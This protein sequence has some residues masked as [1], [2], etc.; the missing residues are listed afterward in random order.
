EGSQDLCIAYTHDITERK[1]AEGDRAH[2]EALLMAAIAQTPA[3]VIIADAPDVRIRIA[4]SAAL[5]IRGEARYALTG[6]PINLHPMHWQTFHPD[7]TPFAPEDLPLSR[8]ILYGE[9]SHDVDVII[10]RETGEDRWVLAN[11]APIRNDK[12]EIIAGVVVFP[13]ITERKRTEEQIKKLNEE[14]EHRVR[15][16]TAQ[17]QTANKELESF[18]YS[19]SH[20]LRAPLR[21]IDGF[22]RIFLEE[23][24]D[25]L[26]AE[27]RR[28]LDVI[29]TNT[30]QMGQLIDDLLSFSR[31]SRKGLD[32][33]PV[34]MTELAQAIVQEIQGF[35][36][37]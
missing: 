18:S 28:L 36:S 23:Y 13:D 10:R 21:A 37:Q 20:D 35:E 4:N 14:L 33:S 34:D 26:D 1:A 9:T 24:S 5:G 29:C 7:G 25:R 17:L 31:L 16:R 3:G 22:S 32:R 19:V 15:E 12:G 11:A 8:A 2:T 27:G 6:I 30:R